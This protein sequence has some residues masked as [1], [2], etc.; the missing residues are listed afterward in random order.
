VLDALGGRDE[1]SGI[2]SQ[3][4]VI[5]VKDS[6]RSLTTSATET[7]DVAEVVRRQPEIP[8]SWLLTLDF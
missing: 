3:E 4:L 6:I 2:R 1:E 8:D 7:V 5:K